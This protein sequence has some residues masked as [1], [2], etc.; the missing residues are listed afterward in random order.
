MSL[1]V[2]MLRV[3]R[4]HPEYTSP[5]T[6]VNGSTYS[7][8]CMLCPN[9]RSRD[10][11]LAIA[12]RIV[13]SFYG[14]AS[15]RQCRVKIQHQSK[16]DDS[17]W[18]M[19]VNE[20]IA[21]KNALGPFS[22]RLLYSINH[23]AL[24]F[25]T[26]SWVQLVL[27]EF[28]PRPRLPGSVENL[29]PVVLAVGE[30]SSL[31]TEILALRHD[32]FKLS[33]NMAFGSISILWNKW[34]IRGFVMLSL[35]LQ[36]HLIG[37]ISHNQS[38]PFTHV[39]EVDGA[40]LAFWASFLLLH[41][42][43]PDTIAAFSMEDS[44]LWRRHLLSLVFQVGSGIY[45]FMQIFPTNKSLLI[46]MMLVF[47][48][49]VIKNVERMV[50]LNFSSLLKLRDWP[51]SQRPSPDDA[52]SYS[53]VVLNMSQLE[54]S[55]DE[56][57]K[58]AESIVVKHAFCLFQMFMVLLG[59]LMFT[60]KDRQV[61]IEY[62]H[63]VSAMDALRVISVELQLMYEVLHTKTLAIRSIWSYIFRF[64]AFTNVVTAFVLFN[65]FKKHH[66]P[67]LDVEITYSLLFGGIALDVIA[68]L[69]LVFSDWTIVGIK[70]VS[71]LNKFIV[72]MTNLRKP[73]FATCE[74][75]P[76][77]NY[78]YTALDT[79]LIFQRW[80]ESISAC[81][82]LSEFTK[83][84]P[85]KML[86]HGRYSGIIHNQCWGIIH[87]SIHRIIHNRC[88]GI[89]RVIHDR[90][91]GILRV[92]IILLHSRLSPLKAPRIAN[93]KYVSKNPFIK[94]LWIFIFKEVRHKSLSAYNEKVVRDIFEAK[95]DFFLESMWRF[96]YSID[97]KQYVTNVNFDASIIIWHIATEICYNIETPIAKNEER[98]FSK[99]LSDYMIYLLL[100]QSNLMS[101][102][103][104]IAQYRSAKMLEKMGGHERDVEELCARLYSKSSEIEESTLSQGIKLAK[105]MEGFEKDKW[106]VMSGVWV[107]MLSYAAVHIKGETHVQVLSQ[108]GEL[109]A[110]VWLL[111]AHFGCFYNPEWGIAA[112]Y[113]DLQ[114]FNK[115]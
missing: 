58:L 27:A 62:F 76:N 114:L 46:P 83:K 113:D 100:N 24:S 18:K 99:I 40:L 45:V 17:K 13:K 97:Y 51:F 95:G 52:A 61:S 79:P 8:S 35:W 93:T 111:M 105:E 72:A 78:A 14:K 71:F 108:G 16:K 44:A 6:E 91:C 86:K 94:E 103:V 42:G 22:A 102:V 70:Q 29:L 75:H 1:N 31:V 21:A 84:S 59:D 90:C 49:G 32:Q 77:A 87:D 41:L 88:C 10:Y 39:A 65:R 43:G 63:K 38:N 54:F 28:S 112:N 47:L 101:T 82:L 68:L 3:V 50:A 15:I 92:I 12:S 104:G 57:V 96:D 20:V 110:F 69:M 64:I 80:S 33:K 30:D 66:L 37:L 73:R 85:R 7:Q 48:A 67:D 60:S 25:A 98:E 106:E 89:L 81:N 74:A 11:T 2:R 109:L 36:L 19:L 4:L 115:T 5:V 34:N 56:E 55:S 23:R 53:K 26:V 9:A 107:E